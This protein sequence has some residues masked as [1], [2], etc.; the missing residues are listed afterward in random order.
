ML[1]RLRAKGD[2]MSTI[3][4]VP[5]RCKGCTY[6]WTHGIK[7]GGH[8]AWCGNFGKPAANAKSE[9]ILQSGYKEKESK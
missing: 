7:T 9:C 1:R 8:S 5:K 4:K 3:N 2:G 6:L